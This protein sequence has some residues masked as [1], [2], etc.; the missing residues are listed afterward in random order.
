MGG[1]SSVNSDIKT[2]LYST[3]AAR[4]PMVSKLLAVPEYYNMYAD[5]VK[6]IASM[7]SNPENTVNQKALLIRDHIK[8]DPR[9]LFTAEQFENNIAKTP[10]GL[11]VSDDPGGNTG[12]WGNWGGF[13]WAPGDNNNPGGFGDW[14]GGFG[15]WGGG[16][17]D[18]FGGENVSV[19]DFL[20][21]RLEVVKS[22]LGF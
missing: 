10:G 8:A 14:G 6:Q 18:G 20:I 15:D 21:K 16:F 19:T 1:A 22:A 13:V 2:A 7:Y 17:G 11:Q 5:Y 3:D 9:Y 4:R 12:D